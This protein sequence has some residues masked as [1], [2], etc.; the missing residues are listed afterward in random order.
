MTIDWAFSNENDRCSNLIAERSVQNSQCKMKQ[1][2]T[3]QY[4]PA[5]GAQVVDQTALQEETAAQRTRDI[6]GAAL[7]FNRWCP[8]VASAYLGHVLCDDEQAAVLLHD[9][10]EQLH[11]V[12]VSE[13]PETERETNPV[14]FL[15]ARVTEHR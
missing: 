3:S 8:I 1:S 6:T 10:T 7:R 13:L 2:I 15:H 9:H 5:S 14:I 4:C 12:V 11:Q